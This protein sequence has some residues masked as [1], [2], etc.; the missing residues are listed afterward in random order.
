MKRAILIF[1][2]LAVVLIPGVAYAVEL[3]SSVTIDNVRVFR[4][5]AESG[6]MLIAFSYDLPYT[7]DNYSTTP[8]SQTILFRL[9]D[10]SGN[11][12]QTT[13]PYVYPLFESNGYGDGM[14]AF[15]FGASDDAPAWSS[16]ATINIH[17]FPTY[18]SG[19]YDGDLSVYK[20]LTTSEY[21]TATT[22]EANQDLLR[23]YILLECDKLD[24]DYQATGVELK[25]SSDIGTVLS[26]YGEHYFRGAIPGLQYLCPELFFVQ[27]TIPEQM[28]VSYDMSLADTYTDRLAGDD[29]GNGFERLG[30]YFGVGGA[31][32]AAAL[33]VVLAVVAMIWSQRKYGEPY[34]GMGIGA[35]I[36]VG[37]ALLVG[38]IVFTLVMI[39]SLV[40]VMGI[41]W[42]FI[43]KKA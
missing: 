5:L 13:S 3:P 41:V 30:D 43:L 9:Y 4:N 39:G 12:I 32:A 29:L 37:M 14:S 33:V 19:W 35:V 26:S 17:G 16:N 36:A 6:D 25:A 15:Y 34:L 40:G 28:E 22:Q 2:L 11:L 21:V 24:A 23:D 38:D 20:T 7:S 8:A 31:F 27:T 1:V 42:L 10:A 18:F